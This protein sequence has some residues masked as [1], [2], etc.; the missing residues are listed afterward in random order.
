MNL[1]K[2]VHSFLMSNS[3]N[4]MCRNNKQKFCL[5]SA[6]TSECQS[7]RTHPRFLSHLSQTQRSIK[8]SLGRLFY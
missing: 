1:G 7:Y 5:N 2:G 3:S 6:A 8:G 4:V